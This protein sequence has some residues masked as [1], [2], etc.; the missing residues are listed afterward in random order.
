MRPLA[1]GDRAA[2]KPMPRSLQHAA[3]VGGILLALQLLREGQWRSLRTKTL[4][5]SP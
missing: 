5:R 3:E 2:M 4:R 1:W